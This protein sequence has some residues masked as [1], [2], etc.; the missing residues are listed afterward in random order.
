VI[1][2]ILDGVG[3]EALPDAADYGDE[4]AATLPHVAE[5]CGG[6]NLPNLQR[7]G[8]GNLADIKGVAPHP[9]PCGAYG[10]LAERSVGKDSVVGHWELAGVVLDEPFATYPQGFPDQLIKKFTEIAGMK[11]L[12]NVP[13]SGIS[14]LKSYGAE[15]VRTGRPILYTSVDSVLQ[16]AAHEDILPL[17]KLYELCQACKGL[18]DEYKLARVIARPFV[19]SE[20]EGYRRTP[21]RKDFATPPPRATLLECLTACNYTVSTVGKISDLFAGRGISRST[22]TSDNADGMQKTL[23]ELNT[24]GQGLLMVNLIDFDMAYGHRKDAVGFGLALEEFDAWLPQ[25]CELMQQHDLLVVS[26]D[27]GCDPT[28]PGT[29]HTREYVP[30]LVWSKAMQA[31]VNLGDR[32]SFADIG[33][34]LAAYFSVSGVDAGVSFIDALALSGR[35]SS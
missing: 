11:P 16:I 33:T 13:A 3:L 29:D 35:V 25:L 6:L 20:C 12:G 2:I 10:R 24:L 17:Q 7:L 21:R 31:G 28:S 23:L 22:S 9:E 32:Q 15:H 18:V 14:I 30:V 8:L 5:A 4:G 19:G 26:A 1:L 34:T 27:H